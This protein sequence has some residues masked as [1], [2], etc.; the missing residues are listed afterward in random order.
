MFWGLDPDQVK[1]DGRLQV[2]QG[3]V[4][5]KQLGLAPEAF[6]QLTFEVTHI[7]HG[8][9]NLKL[10]RPFKEA[11]EE[12]VEGIRKVTEFCR[13]CMADGPF[14]KLEYLSTVSAAG[15][16]TGIIKERPLD[17]VGGFRNS[18]EASKA[19][20]EFALLREMDRGLPATMHR[21][22]MVVGNSMTG[23]V[24]RF[25]IFYYIAELLSGR[26]TRGIIPRIGTRRLDLIPVDWVCRG[27]WLST[28]RP[29]AVGRIFHLCSGPGEMQSLDA[30]GRRVQA[31]LSRHGV[32]VPRKRQIS[33]FWFER[34]LPWLGLTVPAKVRRA[35]ATVPLL[36]A[37]A[38]LDQQY[39]NAETLSFFAHHL[40][41][42]PQ[43]EQYWDN[44]MDFYSR[45]SYVKAQVS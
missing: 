15:R 2:W 10:N 34:L 45:N 41:R 11:K 22:S 7:V 21:P 17:V 28:L 12:A 35:L 24:I 29:D 37:Y 13:A 42:P 8:A 40:P 39:E 1:A 9:A 25:Q 30:I 3:D 23:E 27:I 20:A 31:H 26:K 19:E 33:K 14:E 6:K 38:D 36:M 16:T 4:A 44:I 5:A 18:Y 32:E 43:V